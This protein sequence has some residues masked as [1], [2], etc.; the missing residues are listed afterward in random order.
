M[1]SKTFYGTR[2]SST[3][4]ENHEEISFVNELSDGEIFEPD[5]SSS[6][7][8]SS[9]EDTGESSCDEITKENEVTSNPTLL[10][11]LKPVT[12]SAR[13]FL[14]TGKEEMSVHITAKGEVMPID[15]FELF[16]TD[17]IIDYIVFETNRVSPH[18]KF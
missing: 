17:E 6:L 8:D 13:S 3:I 2:S 9:A 4:V 14:F 7:G 18:N 5:H 16:I 12:A 1:E 10:S 11:G 15:I